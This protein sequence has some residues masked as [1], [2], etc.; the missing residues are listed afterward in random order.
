M[1]EGV[2]MLQ[3]GFA[4]ALIENLGRQAGMPK[5]ALQLADELGLDMALK[6]EQQAA[7]HYGSK[8]IQHPAVPVLK[9]M[10][11]ELRRTGKSRGG[12]FYE[13]MGED[14]QIWQELTGHFP[15]TQ[16][17]FSVEELK[18]RFLFAQV[19]EAG[20]CL[21]EKVIQSVPEANLGSIYGWGF[22]A[23]R[24]GVIQYIFDYGKEAFLEKCKNLEAAHSQ[25]FRVPKYLKKLEAPAPLATV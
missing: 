19:I 23:Y 9:K 17:D 1:L 18:T 20:W 15:T 12:G 6:Y 7:E 24:G 4:P 5:G 22:P 13:N 11:D 3:E 10:I 16:Q 14:A 21:Q 25:R 8:Y 2:T